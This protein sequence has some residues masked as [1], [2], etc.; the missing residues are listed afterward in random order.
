MTEVVLLLL[1]LLWPDG[2]G[3]GPAGY[4]VPDGGQADVGHGASSEPRKSGAS[5]SGHTKNI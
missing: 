5:L 4:H 3:A 1:A 2:A